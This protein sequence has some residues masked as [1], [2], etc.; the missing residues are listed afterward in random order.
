M[1]QEKVITIEDVARVAGVSRAT[2]GRVVG[3]YGSVSEKS[4]QK[5]LNAIEELKYTPNS[6]AQ[7]MRSGKTKLVAIVMGSIHNRM[8]SS[9]A[10]VIEAYAFERGYS[11]IICN[12]NEEICTE[13]MQIK[14]LYGRN[15]DGII[16]VSAYTLE[17]IEK[18]KDWSLYLGATPLVLMDRR[19]DVLPKDLIESDNVGGA[20][21]ATKYLTLLGHKKIGVIGTRNYSSIFDRLKGYRMALED[22]GISFDPT[23]VYLSEKQPKKAGYHLIKQILQ[24]K[25]DITAVFV[26]AD[27]LFEGVLLGLNE[28]C[29][30][31]PDDISL[32][33]WDDTELNELMQI[34]TVH[35]NANVIGRKAIEKL[36]D[37]IKSPEVERETERIE[38]KTELI[39]RKSCR[40]I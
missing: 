16:L 40:R 34:T 8:F 12:T 3:H 37:I 39:I 30:K 31:I 13:Q 17:D 25:P 2:A 7:A 21:E 38:I 28:C 6:M 22:A 11:V 32:V 36:L 15:I 5:V 24:E 10:R 35:Q 33:A 4:K 1:S 9:I 20:Y 29:K 26:L 27:N 19:V 18:E 14:A 23:L